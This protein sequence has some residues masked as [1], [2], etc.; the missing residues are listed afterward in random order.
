MKK[1]LISVWF[2]PPGG[3]MVPRYVLQLLFSEKSQNC[4]FLS[5]SR[6]AKSNTIFEI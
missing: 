1:T 6:E 2:L 4:S 5:L 3:S